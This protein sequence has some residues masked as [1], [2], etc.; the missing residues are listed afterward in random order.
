MPSQPD[1]VQPIC[2]R[3]GGGDD[4]GAGRRSSHRQG[5]DMDAGIC[6]RYGTNGRNKGRDAADDKERGE[7]LRK[8]EAYSKRQKN[9]DDGMWEGGRK[10]KKD[11]VELGREGI[12]G[13]KNH[14]LLRIQI[15]KEWE[16]RGTREEKSEKGQPSDEEN[17]VYRRKEFRRRREMEN[18]SLRLSNQEYSDVWGESVGLGRAG[19]GREGAKEVHEMGTGVAAHN[20]WIYSDGRNERRQISF[21]EKINRDPTKHRLRE[22]W[23]NIRRGEER[24][25]RTRWGEEREKYL[26]RCGASSKWVEMA[27][28]RGEEVSRRLEDRDKEVQ[29]QERRDKIRNS[30]SAAKYRQIQTEAVPECGNEERGNKYWLDEVD[31]VCRICGNEEETLEHLTKRCVEE[32][33]WNGE[34]RQ[35]VDEKGMDRD[36]GKRLE[37]ARRRAAEREEQDGGTGGQPFELRG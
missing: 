33:R 36:W 26:N 17:M 11:R 10:K 21:E 4:E 27:R 30:R 2:S 29:T 35:I 34:T 23:K 28:T 7:I 5:K 18:E 19:R 3:S 25:E 37:K 22:C 14:G 15:H 8:K 31:R 9:D 13:N 24:G 20:T 16:T 6:G 32:L 12:G 1:T